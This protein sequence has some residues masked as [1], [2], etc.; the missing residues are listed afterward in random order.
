MCL[1]CEM[2]GVEKMDLG[3]TH[4][5][6]VGFGAQRQEERIVL[7]PY[8][9]QGRLVIAQELLEFWVKRNVA[10]IIE[11]QIELN[12]V[13]AWPRQQ[14]RVESIRFGRNRL[15]RRSAFRVWPFC[16]F[17]REEIAQ[18]RAIGLVGVLP[19]SLDR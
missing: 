3:F 7:P 19:V 13:I 14:D 8:C 2:A 12:L 11:K 6:C 5:A 17:R 4:V 15:C 9:E 1:E 16:H 10:G 18:R